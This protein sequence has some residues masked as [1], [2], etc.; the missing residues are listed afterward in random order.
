MRTL[1][2]VEFSIFCIIKKSFRS[3]ENLH[4]DPVFSSLVSK[5]GRLPQFRPVPVL[6]Q[7]SFLVRMVP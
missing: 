2:R 6:C 5:N 1:G 3:A 4:S 7:L